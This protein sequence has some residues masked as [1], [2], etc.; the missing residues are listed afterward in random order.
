MKITAIFRETT[1]V[2]NANYNEIYSAKLIDYEHLLILVSNQLLLFKVDYESWTVSLISTSNV[3]SA[4]PI[5]ID[6]LNE[7]NFVLYGIAQFC[8]GSLVADRLVLNSSVQYNVGFFIWA[9]LVGNR[10]SGFRMR[11]NLHA[12]VLYWEYCE[13]DL[14]T[15]TEQTFEVRFIVG[16][17]KPSIV[18]FLIL[19]LFIF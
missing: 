15:L 14:A 6:Q 17:Q 7:R 19:L 16:Y 2:L 9:K 10:F 3:A 5:V 12:G 4:Y 8:T 1:V 18:R 11:L 13:I